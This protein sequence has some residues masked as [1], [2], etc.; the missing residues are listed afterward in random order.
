MN[1]ANDKITFFQSQG[2]EKHEYNAAWIVYVCDSCH[3]WRDAVFKL[4]I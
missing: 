4:N 2:I 1:I 3:C